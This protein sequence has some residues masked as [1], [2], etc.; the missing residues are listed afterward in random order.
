VKKKRHAGVIIA[1]YYYDSE[2]QVYVEDELGF[3]LD[4][5]KA[6]E[7][8]QVLLQY[9]QVTDCQT[10]NEE[11]SLALFLHHMRS[12]DKK[13]E[14][15]YENDG[16][17]WVFL[18]EHHGIINSAFTQGDRKKK[19]HE[20]QQKGAHI[21]YVFEPKEVRRFGYWLREVVNRIGLDFPTDYIREKIIDDSL[22]HE[23]AR[24]L[25]R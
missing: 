7:A 1:T 15:K 16:T 8:G 19:E 18:Y 22:Y 24:E 21:F 20:L 17:G 25:I 3:P 13:L 9:A 10:Y 11:R 23:K 12:A 4:P 14:R 5:E 2:G 6:R